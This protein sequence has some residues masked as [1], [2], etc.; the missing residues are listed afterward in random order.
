MAVTVE[1]NRLPPKIPDKLY[2]KIGEVAEIVGVKPYV[3]RY[4]ETEFPEIAPSKSKSKQ[5]LYKRKEVELVLKVRDLLYQ[6]KFTI[7]GARKQLKE[8]GRRGKGK[9][10]KGSAQQI[11]LPLSQGPDTR[12][13]LLELK[14]KL[15]ELSDTLD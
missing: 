5:R 9:R 1:N 13:I 12:K 4:W 10:G 7:N 6:Q 14:K 2:F 15:Q 11:S 8:M 3:L